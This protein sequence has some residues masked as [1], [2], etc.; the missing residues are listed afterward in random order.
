MPRAFQIVV[1]LCAVIFCMAPEASLSAEAVEIRMR[2]EASKYLE[3]V[4]ICNSDKSPLSPDTQIRYLSDEK[5][6][7]AMG[8][9]E[10]PS[11]IVALHPKMG[12]SS[13]FKI[14]QRHETSVSLNDQG[15]HM[16]LLEWKHH[17]SEWSEL[18]CCGDNEFLTE[19]VQDLQ[20]PDVSKEELVEAVRQK[21]DSW[22]KEGYDS[23]ERWLILAEQCESPF[24]YPCAVAVSKITLKI[25][26]SDHGQWQK[27]LEIDL[28][29]PMGC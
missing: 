8:L 25:S 13:V 1:T 11:Q 10:L 4:E 18:Q 5:I 12:S 20:F 7:V 27:I 3:S 9:G 14:D 26:A 17:L 24:D 6:E 23:G 21:T 15:P 28:L 22:R 16:D 19:K 29:I 2:G